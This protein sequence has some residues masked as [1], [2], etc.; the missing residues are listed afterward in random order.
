[1]WLAD[2]YFNQGDKDYQKNSLLPSFFSL[3]KAIDLN[4]SEALYHAD[5]AKTSAKLAIAYHEIEAS[6][7][8]TLSAEF[9]T[10]AKQEIDYALELNPVQLNF[11]KNKAEVYMFLSYLDPQYKEK[12]LLVLLDAVKLAPTDAKTFYNLALFYLDLNNDAQALYYFKKTVNLKPNYLS[13]QLKLAE[14]YQ[15]DGQKDLAR[16]TL[17]F[18]LRYVDPQNKDALKMISMITR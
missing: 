17:Q 12:A 9:T 11:Y 3:S 10:L 4:R 6:R 18:I 13:A 8:A 1:M 2:Y 16:E 7:S 15:K 14:L 5:L